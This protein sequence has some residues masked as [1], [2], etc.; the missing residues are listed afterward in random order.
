MASFSTA[1]TIALPKVSL[2][3]V[4]SPATA[5]VSPQR[6]LIVGQISPGT[7]AHGS[8]SFT[9]NPV[10][11]DTITLGGTAWTFKS[12]GATGTQVNI[13]VSLSATMTALA[14]ALNA[15]AD[16]QTALCRYVATANGLVVVYK[17]TGTAGNAY[18]LAA[19]SSA[20]AV[21]GS[22]LAG[23]AASTATAT[24][25]LNTSLPYTTSD[26]DNAFG[27][28]SHLAQ[29]GRAF[30]RINNVSKL[31]AIALAD[32]ASG[33]CA[34]AT[35]ALSG[36]AL[37]AG[38]LT[39]DFVSS[40]DYSY[41]V[42]VNVGDTATTILTNLM[43]L[44]SVDYE[45]PFIY[46]SDTIGTLYLEA[47]NAG[48]HA[49][50]WLMRVKGAVA[51]IGVTLTSWANGATN[52]SL[53]TVFSPIANIRYQGVVWPGQYP[54][55]TLGNY[56]TPL[57]NVSNRIMDGRG[58]T[59]HNVALSTALTDAQSVNTGQ[60][61]I[62]NNVPTS[63]AA[64]VGPHIPEAPDVIAAQ[65]AAVRALRFEPNASL[66]QVISTNAAN[67]Q[68]GGMALASLPYFNTPFPYLGLPYSGT[69]YNQSSQNAAENGGVTVIGVNDAQTG[70]IAGVVVTT[71]LTDTAGNPDTTWKYLEWIDTH[72][73]VREYITN[74]IRQRFEQSRMTTGDVIPGRDMMNAA[75]LT[76]AILGLCQDLQ[77]ACLIVAGQASRQFLQ[78]NLTV[79]LDPLNRTA[80][81]NLL[82]LQCSQL[83]TIQ[84]SVSF[85]FQTAA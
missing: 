24:A 54:I 13:G 32:N 34:Y 41:V 64:Y 1:S 44:V 83:E 75:L 28:N 76:G 36:T 85:T 17:T 43:S 33:V 18:T 35:M 31:D 42:Q 3:L 67:D 46:V 81:V 68:F 77:N 78:N 62:L 21:S 29:M 55:T 9:A 73:M 6:N 74:N 84:G 71:W 12:S 20:A 61:V 58:F 40:Y 23:G 8:I 48:S 49:N 79:T 63:N 56:L 65:F 2:N 66:S 59:Y 37:R 38:T 10:A 15:S 52:P 22:T 60:V 50:D 11:N 25:G 26:I 69:G 45:Q 16:T 53:T 7:R 82:Y 72:S 30:R 80:T 39:F 47:C 27:S 19:S 4:T 70:V 14:T 57:L 51:G 5:A